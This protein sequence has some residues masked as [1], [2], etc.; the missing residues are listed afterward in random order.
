M[1]EVTD[2]DAPERSKWP[3][4]FCIV[5]VLFVVYVLSYA[6]MVQLQSGH[7]GRPSFRK[8]TFRSGR[9]VFDPNPPTVSGGLAYY[10]P[11]N[12]LIDHTPLREPLFRWAGVWNVRRD[13]ETEWLI[14]ETERG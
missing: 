5:A 9:V 8:L 11:V 6:P 13:F 2:N 14:R 3:P 7:K 1:S 10:S 4:A 12:W